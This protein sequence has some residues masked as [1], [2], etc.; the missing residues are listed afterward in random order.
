MPCS[1]VWCKSIFTLYVCILPIHIFLNSIATYILRA[2]AEA[3]A[4]EVEILNSMLIQEKKDKAFLFKHIKN[5]G[6]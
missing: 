1:I 6:N 3:Y 5:T 2:K 4:I